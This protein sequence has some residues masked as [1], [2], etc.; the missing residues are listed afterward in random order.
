MQRTMSSISVLVVLRLASAAW[1]QSATVTVTHTHA[2]GLVQPGETIRIKVVLT[3]TGVFALHHIAGEAVAS[4]DLGMAASPW[5]Y[6][7]PSPFVNPG[8]PAAGSIRGVDIQSPPPGFLGGPSPYFASP[9]YFL[10]YDWTA[11]AQLGQVDFTW[12]ARPDLPNP[13]F[14]EQFISV[15]PI[16]VPTAYFGTSITVIPA[17]P[18][19]SAVAGLLAMGR[20]RR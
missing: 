5:A 3:W 10:R 2:T 17:P 15:T 19:A 8:S 16:S 1:A 4:P 14:Y 20:R 18:S 11:P 6:G 13:L 9:L 7:G 12:I